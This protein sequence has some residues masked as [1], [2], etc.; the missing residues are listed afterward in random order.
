MMKTT[1]NSYDESNNS[2]SSSFDKYT[3]SEE[4]FDNDL[5]R[6]DEE[7]DL[8]YVKDVN[9]KKKLNILL[10]SAIT[11]ILCSLLLSL[12][13]LVL[14]DSDDNVPANSDIVKYDL[15]V[16]HSNNYY[17][18]N[19]VSFDDYSSLDKSLDYSFKIENK[20]TIDLAYKIK[21][22]NPNFESDRID[23]TLINYEL[24]VN[25]EEFSN[26]KLRDMQDFVLIENNIHGGNSQNIVLKLWSSKVPKDR[27]FAFKVNVES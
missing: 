14:A 17:G 10:V 4:V 23:M 26:G 21:I 1:V 9:H 19:K 27:K 6:M 8:V 3:F 5:H 20:N 25:D 13:G 11:L 12:L 16:T 22:Y 2:D 24:L 7:D 18:R 15:F